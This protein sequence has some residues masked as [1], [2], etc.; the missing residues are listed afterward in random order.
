MSEMGIAASPRRATIVVGYGAFGLDVLRRLLASTA[1]RGVLAWEE[2]RG[3]GAPS[4]RHLR[5]LALLWMPDRMERAQGPHEKSDE[6]SVDEGSALEMMRDLYRQIQKIESPSDAGFARALSAA[7]EA[8]LSAAA[9]AGRRDALPLGLDVIVLARP[10]SRE[11][12]GTLDR[13]LLQAMDL[14]ANNA[15]LERAVQGVEA[16]NFV[17][18]LDFE[19]YWDRSEQG[20]AIRRTILGSVEQWQRRRLSGKPAFGRFYLVDG[21]TDDGIREPFERI[22]E[23]SLLL[24]LL[25][26][27]G[28]RDGELQRLYQPAGRH[29]SPVATFGIRLTE[30]S[31]GLLGHLA[32]ARFGIGWLEYLSAAA[33]SRNGDGPSHVRQ[34]LA[35]YEPEALDRLLDASSLRAEVEAELS[36]L[37]RELTALPVEVP[38][39]PQRVRGRYEETAAAL[40]SRLSAKAHALMAK[41]A[42]EHLAGLPGE[43][44][45]GIEADLHDQRDPVPAGGV[46]EELEE[47]LARLEPVQEVAMPPSGGAE[48]MLQSIETLHSDYRQFHLQRV[49]VEGL[50]RWWP[51]LAVAVA[52][53]ATPILHELLGDV[54][55]PDPMRFLLDRAYAA[56]QW[57]NNPLALGLL[58]FLLVWA[59]GAGAFQG[60]IAARVER[61]R[62]FYNDPERGRFVDRLRNGLKPGGAL[63]A[64]IDALID[65][66]LQDMLLSVRGDVTRELGRVLDRLRERRREMLWLRDQLRGFLHMHG[67]AGE[68]LRPDV[69]RLE[70]DGTGIR[71]AMERWEDF[72]IMLRSNPPTPER[73]RSMQA[74]QGPFSGWGERYSR[75]FLVPLEFLDRLS[76]AYRDPFERELARA[77]SG[78]EQRRLSEEVLDF[79]AQ[80]GSF[81][82][83]FRF[84]A[85]EGVP[86]DRRYCL[87]PSLWRRLPGVLPAL[88]DLQ[89][90]DE[91][92]LAAADGGRA[93]LLRMQTGVDPK[94]LLEPE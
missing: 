63:R 29:E 79:L 70:R 12:L 87:L 83:A 82:L 31:A 91:A 65:R 88:A 28:Q 64:P 60:R 85:Q 66:L 56:L 50:R 38:D 46:I 35:P 75:A 61:S 53:G 11:A 21:R 13:L 44:R 59:V 32:A 80:R 41:I 77:G 74:S 26:F 37:E 58:L 6:E 92:A 69:G 16:L 42:D 9:R 93:Y 39:W 72:E 30:R 81:S 1:P 51:L 73:F 90:G 54:P 78:P 19:N 62:R 68:E 18:I 52:A 47:S 48:E 23:I 3:G 71:Y 40:R 43:L 76:R 7:A 86:P 55:Q 67:F 27:E 34:R 94:C 17:A 10:T 5:D 45:S 89:V 84:P 20:L 8:L 22:D 4:E 15:N 25:L 24:E 57:I 33:P 36:E 2:A 49:H 14:L